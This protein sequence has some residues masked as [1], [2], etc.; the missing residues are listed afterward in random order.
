MNA[1]QCPTVAELADFH[2]GNL[3]P[4]R[5]DAVGVHVEACADCERWLEERDALTDDALIAVK[6]ITSVISPTVGLDGGPPAGRPATP[7]T[8]TIIGGF[9]VLEEL[10]R[11]GMGVVYRAWHPRLRRIVAL[12]VLSSGELAGE[13]ER[14]RFLAEAE[15]IARLR[16]PN[17]VQIFEVGEWVSAAGAV[18]PFLALEF[19]DGGN[20]PRHTANRPQP[21]GVAAAWVTTLARAVQHA[22]ENGVIHRDLKPSNVLLTADGQLKLCDFGVAKLASGPELQTRT[23]LL[24]GTPEYMA[25]E[26]AGE[27]QRVGPAADVWALGAILYSLLTGRPPFSAPDGLSVLRRL[28][29]DDPLS[30]RH[31]QPGIARDLETICLKCLRKEPGHRY[32]TAGQLADDLDRF[33]QGI[34]VIARPTGLAERGW[35]WVRRRPGTATAL[36]S[37]LVLLFVGLPATT[38]LWLKTEGAR[39]ETGAALEQADAALY[40]SRIALAQ[41]GLSQGDLSQARLMLE[42]SEPAAPGAPDRRG[43]EWHYLRAQASLG[44]RPGM[45][46]EFNQWSWVYDVAWSP[47]GR[48][49]VSTAA[50]VGSEGSGELKFWDVDSGRCDATVAVDRGGLRTVAWHPDGR[51]IVTGGRDG[52]ILQWD[53]SASPPAPR[54][55][56]RETATGETVNRLRF[57]PDARLLAAGTSHRLRI[58]D[59]A[60]KADVLLAD[61]WTCES[62][63][64]RPGSGSSTRR[65]VAGRFA[66]ESPV[67]MWDIPPSGP[68]AE[69]TQP[70]GQEHCA[71]VAFGEGKSDGLISTAR[72]WLGD[73]DI[74]D[75]AGKSPPTRLWGQRS[76]VAA[77]AVSKDGRL[78]AGNELGA[79]QL[80]DAAT[81]QPEFLY[82]AHTTGVLALA[83]SPDGTRLASSGKDGDICIHDVTRD[84][85]G[86]S[87]R[88]TSTGWGEHLG[89]MALTPDGRTVVAV[90][91]LDQKVYRYDIESGRRTSTTAVP[92]SQKIEVPRHDQALRPDGERLAAPDPEH[93]ETLVLYDTRDGRRLAA[94]AGHERK[95][96][97]VAWS[98]DGRVLA[99]CCP[100]DTSKYVI[101]LWDP[102]SGE[103]TGRLDVAGERVTWLALSDD[104]RQLAASTFASTVA[105]LEGDTPTKVRL[106]DLPGGRERPALEG[107]RGVAIALTFRPDGQQLAAVGALSQRVYTWDLDGSRRL[108]S[109]PSLTLATRLAYS[110]DGGRLAATCHDNHVRVWDSAS[111]HEA[112]T[113][114]SLGVPGSGNYGFT[115]WIAFTPTAGSSSPATGAPP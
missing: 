67:R 8:G 91:Q 45:R 84:P 78:A 57:S 5:L 51:S 48:R 108:L 81:G 61:G 112:I 53:L 101:R 99:S 17:I 19:V 6:S 9:E 102:E 28:Q 35:K 107:A 12:K 89:G 33:R 32:E 4:D 29:Q 20:L 63:A 16:H 22:H 100:V 65:I 111:E 42:G 73:V 47:D 50:P 60:T 83:F 26:Q 14:R 2:L 44:H 68:A 113:L 85:R 36:A 40:F 10:G 87:L 71:A 41:R 86:L 30:P 76:K 1:T 90:S 52:R 13:S 110:P 105:S 69:I 94:L 95:P 109:R 24:I 96:T 34:T 77:L 114:T 88:A 70:P 115:G 49:L 64:F 72:G 3:P 58:R 15:A 11:G 46:H 55:L 38:Y 37:L 25:P 56:W 23:G 106:W 97:S 98:R 103:E 79:V 80:W 62:L 104:G 31:L 39:R 75:Q 59:L 92:L 18:L 7:L 21:A 54:E 74:R 27:A 66:L 93:P 43:W 82:G